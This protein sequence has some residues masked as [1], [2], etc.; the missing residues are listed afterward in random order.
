MAED[1]SFK[2]ILISFLLASL[3][4]ISIF[5]FGLF[6]GFSYGFGADIMETPGMN[7]NLLNQTMRTTTETTSQGW[8]QSYTNVTTPFDPEA[9]SGFE[10]TSL[11]KIA[12]SMWGATVG[13]FNFIAS[14]VVN[15][16][17]VDPLVV[18]VIFTILII[19]MIFGIWRVLKRGD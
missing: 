2:S 1:I 9:E 13:L 19:I 10:F 3:F 17:G 4:I 18:G 12:T 7:I 6:T 16:L 14:S 8:E 11:W 15:I 5:N